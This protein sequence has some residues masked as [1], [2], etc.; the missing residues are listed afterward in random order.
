MNKYVT[1]VFKAGTE[2]QHKKI[3]AMALEESCRA[4]SLDHEILRAE[5]MRH[6]IENNDLKKAEELTPNP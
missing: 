5:L 6:A 1:L 3:R 4:W 2:E